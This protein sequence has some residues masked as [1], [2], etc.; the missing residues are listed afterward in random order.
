MKAGVSDNPRSPPS[1]VYVVDDDA[2]LREALRSLF[3]SVGLQVELFASAV[4]FMA[5]QGRQGPGCIVLDVRLPGM[6]GL[7]FQAQLAKAGI[8]MPIVFMTGH[9]DIPMSVQA[10]K[11]GAFDFLTKPFR[12]QDMLDAVF[13][14]LER[15]RRRC[16]EEESNAA[17]SARYETLSSREKEV[18][19][20]VAKGLI[21]KQIAWELGIS[22]ITVKVHRGNVMRKMAV[23]TLPDLVRIAE[24][25]NLVFD[26]TS[27]KRVE[28]ERPRS[29]VDE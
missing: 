26:K 22:E 3:R 2:V 15:D 10:M 11:A 5:G 27:Q 24:Q 28:T 23:R 4:D 20:L 1:V 14:A 8:H 6:G 13:T 21:N 16:E 18:M 19:F 12:D 25:L 7:D 9:G 17:A 29:S